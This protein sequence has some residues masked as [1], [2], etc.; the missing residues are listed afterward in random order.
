MY[1]MRL[2]VTTLLKWCAP[3]AFGAWNI[4][5]W[6]WIRVLYESYIDDVWLVINDG[7]G[8]KEIFKFATSKKH[9]G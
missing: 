6:D 2:I 9:G 8:D 3:I 5:H 7:V 1:A 4:W